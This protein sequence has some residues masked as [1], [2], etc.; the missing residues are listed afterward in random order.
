MVWGPWWPPGWI[1]LLPR[2]GMAMEIM[3]VGCSYGDHCGTLRER[4][5][6]DHRSTL[7]WC[8]HKDLCGRQS[9][10]DHCGSLG[11]SE[12][13]GTCTVAELNV[14]SRS[15]AGV[16]IMVAPKGAWCEDHQCAQRWHGHICCTLG[17]RSPR[18]H[19]G[20]QW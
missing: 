15:G 14:V 17:W 12:V 18:D 8:S 16:R 20:V 7:R 10:G 11:P 6:R 5:R 19:G 9:G 4:S 3:V 13:A 1:S 2:G